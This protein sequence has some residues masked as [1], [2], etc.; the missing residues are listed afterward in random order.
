MSYPGEGKFFFDIY[1]E[2]ISR[3]RWQTQLRQC[4]LPVCERSV[5]E[6]NFRPRTAN[7]LNLPEQSYRRRTVPT[8]SAPRRHMPERTGWLCRSIT[9]TRNILESLCTYTRQKSTLRTQCLCH[10]SI[11]NP[12]KVANCNT[13]LQTPKR[14]EY[15]SRLD[16]S[17]AILS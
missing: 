6:M 12:I 9:D 1:R 8:T 16:I 11:W 13:Y 14:L 7:D 4:W 5:S 10:S 3:T 15:I 17:E 2:L